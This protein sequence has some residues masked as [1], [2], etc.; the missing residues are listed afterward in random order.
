MSAAEDG[1][2]EAL[3][4]APMGESTD[5]AEL[6][7]LQEDWMRAVQER[8]EA[9]LERLV[10]ERFRFTAVHL[11]PDP[12]SREAWMGAAMSGYRIVSFAY[13]NVEVDISGDTAVV[14][15]R[16]SQI[17]SFRTVDLSNVFRLTDVWSRQDGT[18][19]VVARH[20]SVLR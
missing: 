9:T 10:G 18:W 5:E 14:H 13:E 3:A 6:V 4:S 19:K 12:M 7:R 2:E 16:Y 20:S 1:A 8:D 15:S 17:A 11:D